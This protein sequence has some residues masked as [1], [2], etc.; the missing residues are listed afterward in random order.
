MHLNVNA[1]PVLHGRHPLEV[2][3]RHIQ[4]AGGQGL[5]RARQPTAWVVMALVA[6]PLDTHDQAVSLHHQLVQRAS[7]LSHRPESNRRARTVDLRH[8]MVFRLSDLQ[9]RPN[10]KSA[11][12]DC[13]V[14]RHLCREH[15]SSNLA[16]DFSDD[17]AHCRGNGQAA[18]RARGT[19]NA[20]SLARVGEGEVHAADDRIDDVLR[21]TRVSEKQDALRFFAIETKPPLPSP[22]RRTHH[23]TSLPV[24][25]GILDFQRELRN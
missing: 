22:F 7:V 13:H 23:V 12:G 19:G 4:I 18:S 2:F 20:A 1:S 10:G 24:R 8:E 3:A 15:E 25:L 5:K 21:S 9:L 16:F 6:W 11:A 17:G 14:K